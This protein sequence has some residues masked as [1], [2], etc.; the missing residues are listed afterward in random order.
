MLIS[1]VAGA[2]L[3]FLA[4]LGLMRWRRIGARQAAAIAALITVGLYVPYA[5]VRWPGGDIF[6]IHL[7]IYLLTAFS[8]GL[9]LDTDTGGKKLHWGPAAIIG[10]FVVV[11]ILGAIFITVAE[12]GLTPSIWSRLL[13]ATS[14]GRQVTS[15][16]PGVISHDF[17]Q[18]EALYNQYL[19]QV[20]QQRQR[21]WQVQ[22]GWVGDVIAKQSSTFRVAVQTREG[23][24]VTGAVVSG[25]FLR[26]SNSKEDVDFMLV[27]TAPGVYERS[28]VLPLAG[29]WNLVLHIR[30]EQELHEVRALTQ[31]AGG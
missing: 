22:K 13:P 20:E 18:K 6:A 28:V 7:G 5:I 19:E 15:V 26:P 17:H 27:E 2:A 23:N 8:C 16:F 11:A 31:V 9:W 3:I 25:Q 14:S 1:L 21:G 12:R 10:F 4:N 30:K 29:A 24:P